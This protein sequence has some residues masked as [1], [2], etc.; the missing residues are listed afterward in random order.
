M[1]HTYFFHYIQHCI[2]HYNLDSLLLPMKSMYMYTLFCVTVGSARRRAWCF[3]MHHRKVIA[4]R[5]QTSLCQCLW[6]LG[7]QNVL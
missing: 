2:Y 1:Y 7:T 3:G 6:I 4:I 5:R